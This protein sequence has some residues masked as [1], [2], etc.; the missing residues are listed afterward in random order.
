MIDRVWSVVRL[1]AVVAALERL[2][3]P[4]LA[5]SWDAVGLVCGDPDARVR[6]VL[7]AVDPVAAVVDEALEWR[8]DLV[9]THHPLFLRPVHGVPAT[10]PKG[11]LVHRLITGGVALHTAHTNADR[12]APGVNDALAAALGLH[13]TRPL[14][15]ADDGDPARGLGRVG[16]LPRPEPLSA[17]VRRVAAA[18]P[19]TAAGV[20]AMGDP[21][22]VVAT[23]AVCGGA[24]DSLLGAVRATGADAYVTADLRHHPS[25]EAGEAGGPALV[26]VAHWASEWPWLPDAAALLT[27][28]LSGAGATVE[29]R[30]STTPTDPWTLHRIARESGADEGAHAER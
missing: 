20:R 8:A 10:T 17:F 22:A 9:V 19:A 5:E 18:L 14:V 4:E 12:A 21:D 29:T 28:E 2:Y 1:A 23:V 15:P 24:G 7:F 6:R 26:D 27:A 25:S 13:D 30:V 3:P 16:R 11:R